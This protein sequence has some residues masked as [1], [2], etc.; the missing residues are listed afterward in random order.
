MISI[1]FQEY[2]IKQIKWFA[3]LKHFTKASRAKGKQI[4]LNT[5]LLYFSHIQATSLKDTFLLL[6]GLY[7]LQKFRISHISHINQLLASR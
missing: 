6:S 1:L 7:S 5:Q 4:C 2:T 3:Q